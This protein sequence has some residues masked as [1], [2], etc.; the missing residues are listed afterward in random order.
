MQIKTEPLLIL[1]AMCV[2]A[3]STPQWPTEITVGRFVLWL[4]IIFLLHTLI[5]DLYLYA[6]L[7]I[8]ASERK[9]AQCFCVES[10]IGILV[11]ILGL[12]LLIGNLGGDLSPGP[13][14]W[15]VAITICMWLNYW[16]KDFV[17]SWRPWRIYRDPDHLNIVPRFRIK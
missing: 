7:R 11:M 1:G 3:I 13:V 17:F 2:T 10:G 6:R 14:G 5:R 16:I 4:S 15:F 8:T 9:E 12:A